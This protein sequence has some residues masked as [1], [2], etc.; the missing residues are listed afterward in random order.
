M[1][2]LKLDDGTQMQTSSK[3]RQKK[4]RANPAEAEEEVDEAA[5]LTQMQRRVEGRSR[6]AVK[7]SE[8]GREALDGLRDSDTEADH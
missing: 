1:D 7:L 8:R 2:G 5:A 4:S 3:G 6:R